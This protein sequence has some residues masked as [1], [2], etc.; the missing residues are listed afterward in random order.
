MKISTI[1]ENK[2]LLKQ[3]RKTLI[4]TFWFFIWE[5]SSLFINN[6]ILLPT[7]KKVF[8]TLTIIGIKKCF[9]VSVFKSIIRVI[10]GIF[11]S[12]VLGISLGI[13]AG[14]N[15]FI[16]ELLEPLVVTIKATPVM[17]I[18][19]IALVWFKS[20]YVAIF[21][22]ILMCFPII[23]TNVLVGIKSVDK[24]LIEMA[25][26]YKV[27]N[28]YI[29]TDIYIPAIKPY[30][31]SGI[32]MCLGIG[33]KVSVASEVLSTPKY[34][35]GLNLLNAKATLATEELFSWTIVVILL[36]LIFENMFKYYVKKVF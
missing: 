17:S 8:E 25:N 33:W 24:N 11:M 9:W 18:I 15:I 29:L 1:K 6:E 7:P 19:I 30:T 26:L 21:T 10:I 22:S 13:I 23:Y 16:E 27:K 32:L 35:I 2:T 4:I 20:S 14:T 3:V 5:L 36:S 31:I 12:I 28:K 34:S